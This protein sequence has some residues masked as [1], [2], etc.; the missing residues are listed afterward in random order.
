[1]TDA[2]LRQV[3]VSAKRTTHPHHHQQKPITKAQQHSLQQKQLPLEGHGIVVNGL[4]RIGRL[5][6]KNYLCTTA[7]VV[8][9]SSSKSSESSESSSESTSS[10]VLLLL[11][12]L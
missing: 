7:S 6:F 3:R 2:I 12:L 9:S 8:S 1:M 11:L 4:G 5:I 10:L